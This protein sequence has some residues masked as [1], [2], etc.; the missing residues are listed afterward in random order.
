MRPQPGCNWKWEPGLNKY[1]FLG[2]FQVPALF[3]DRTKGEDV[4]VATAVNKFMF[5]HTTHL[6][7]EISWWACIGDATRAP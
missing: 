1:V 7:L 6:L 4:K 3:L 5:K 2:W